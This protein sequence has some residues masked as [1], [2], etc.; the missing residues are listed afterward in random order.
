MTDTTH[1]Y[2]ELLEL[3]VLDAHGL[4][5]PIESEIFNRSFHEAPASI[6]DEIIRMQLE[7]ATDDSLLPADLPTAELRK[8][9]LSAVANAAD[10]EA[11]FLAPL[12][13]IGARVGASKRGVG[14]TGSVVLW[15]TAA[16]ILFGVS[17]VLAVVTLDVKRTAI[18][19]AQKAANVVANDSMQN[20]TNTK[21]VEFINNP[22]YNV[23]RLERA[24]GNQAGY[25]RVAIYS[26]PVDPIDPI[27]A[28]N[29]YAKGYVFGL[30]LED[31]EEII[32]QGITESGTVVRLAVIVADDSVVA[33]SFEIPKHLAKAFKR[34]EGV[35]AKTGARWIL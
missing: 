32:I 11:R 31:G 13:L 20:L 25:I 19:I 14:A 33:Q 12:A 26:E 8:K 18:N 3:A 10:N 4:L 7:F 28:D 23:T 16:M 2:S 15:R 1:N 21:F 35:N 5:E 17:V 34:I 22:Y 27:G 6:Q 9:V 24:E 30:D 29:P